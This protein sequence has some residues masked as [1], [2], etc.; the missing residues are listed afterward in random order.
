MSGLPRVDY[1][2]HTSF[3]DGE[4]TCRQVLDRARERG[5]DCV[6]ITDHFDRYDENE[7][8]RRITEA[9]LLEHFQSI[10]EYGL[11][12]GQRVICGI[13]TCTDFKG[14][15]RLSD[16]VADSCD[17]IITSPHYVEY[18]GEIRRGNL[19]DEFYWEKYKQKVLNIAA[20]RGDILGHCE[21][22]LPI[23]RLLTPGTT[24]YEQRK[25][26]CRAIAARFF[27]APYIS[28]LTRA[29]KKSGKAVEL[30]CVTATPRERVIK[31]LIKNGVRLSLGSDAH[32]LDGVGNTGW[33]AEM[34][35]KY[36]GTSLLLLK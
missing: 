36:K 9:E 26:L 17:I 29:L 8:I 32:V 27:D 34:L 11:R 25:E 5:L 20:G 28:E 18:D 13:E 30:H 33:G 21:G 22:Y 19:Y 24:T 12:I 31:E 4:P 23:G 6:A 16:R 15:L 35:E 3:S 7:K 2:I 14:D 10:R 1:H